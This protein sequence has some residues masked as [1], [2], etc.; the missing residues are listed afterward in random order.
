M[1]SSKISTAPCLVQFARRA[2]RKP[3]L[4]LI[5]FML[6]ATAST[7]TQAISPPFSANNSFTW[8][9]SL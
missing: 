4:G 1:T 2:S 8:S 5:R 6:P 7:M 3:A 9:M